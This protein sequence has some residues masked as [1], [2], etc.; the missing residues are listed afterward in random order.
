MTTGVSRREPARALAWMALAQLLFA[1]MGIGAR[2]GGRDVP[3]QEV[4]ATRFTVGA[5]TAYVV[6][7]LRGQSLRLTHLRAA[8]MRSLFGTL[9]AFGTFYVYASPQLPIGDAVTLL[10][11]S[12]IFVA[13]L[14]A[15]LLGERVRPSIVVALALGF[16]G[17]VL[18]AQ[19]SFSTAGHLV[20]AGTGAALAGSMAMVWLR[21]IGPNESSEAIVLHFSCVGCAAM[22]LAS[23]PVWKTPTAHDAMPLAFMGLSGGLAQIAMTRAY[24]LDHA[25]RVSAMALSSVAFM[26]LLAVPVFGEVPSLVQAAGSLLVIGSGVLLGTARLAARWGKLWSW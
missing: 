25:A 6:A 24:T 26:R 8:W 21:R 18:V 11:T 1:V 20:A 4:A 22:L 17:I 19:P 3:W 10:A 13:L 2:I 7:R 16:S 14:S 15:P 5:V 9:S 23:I 12:P